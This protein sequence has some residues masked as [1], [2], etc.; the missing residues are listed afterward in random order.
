MHLIFA[1]LS[2]HSDIYDSFKENWINF[3]LEYNKCALQKVKCSFYFIY[4]GSDDMYCINYSKWTDVYF[5]ID[6][7]MQNMIKKSI[8]FF[9]M[10]VSKF[11]NDERLVI[12]SN[13]TTL[14]DIPKMTKWIQS[15]EIPF[16][17][18]F[19]GPFVFFYAKD[20]TV[21]SGTCMMLSMDNVRRIIK[22]KGDI[23]F[24]F[25]ED[26]E[27]SLL[28]QLNSKS[29]TI[30]VKR[31]DFGDKVLYH[32]CYAWDSSIFCFRFRSNNRLTDI[33]NMKTLIKGIFSSDFNL[34]E[35]VKHICYS[36]NKLE[37]IQEFPEY[38]VLYSRNVFYFL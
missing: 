3:I 19:G 2:S 10:L 37:V 18:F 6:E 12:R 7:T 34:N 22:H 1:I 27:L 13:L 21:V 5:N 33:T 26:N 32:K 25:M 16:Q 30:C 8:L 35:F 29:S 11:P 20:K 9:E 38:A 28:V 4:G 24:K 14:F 23:L 15:K 17:N 31:L 36:Q